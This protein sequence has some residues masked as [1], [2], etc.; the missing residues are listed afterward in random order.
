[1]SVFAVS[2]FA[3]IMICCLVVGVL[4][5]VR[6][7][8]TRTLNL[9]VSWFSRSVPLFR[10]PWVHL[11]GQQLHHKLAPTWS[12]CWC[13]GWIGS[14]L[15]HQH[16]KG[17]ESGSLWRPLLFSNILRNG[18]NSGTQRI[19][20]SLPAVSGFRPRQ[21]A[22]GVLFAACSERNSIPPPVFLPLCLIRSTRMLL[23]PLLPLLLLLKRLPPPPPPPLHLSTSSSL[24]LASVERCSVCSP[25][26]APVEALSLRNN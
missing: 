17:L 2:L 26:P 6:P 5:A 10:P 7:S 23:L 25:S 12:Y 21:K 15:Y 4:Y 1:M 22:W 18:A 24:R 9:T 8:R 20:S 19:S 11:Q 13:N 16:L 3:F 14:E